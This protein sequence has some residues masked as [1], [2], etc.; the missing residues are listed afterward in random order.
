VS[1]EVSL[2]YGFSKQQRSMRIPLIHTGEKSLHRE[3]EDRTSRKK[4]GGYSGRAN[5]LIENIKGCCVV[6]HYLA[7]RKP[8]P[9]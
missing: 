7:N 8:Q 4:R 6:F 2:T 1:T 9:T 3:K 5:P